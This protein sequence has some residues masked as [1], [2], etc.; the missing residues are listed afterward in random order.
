MVLSGCGVSKTDYNQVVSE[1]T[2]LKQQVETLNAE[3]DQ[4]KFGAEKLTALLK[5]N[6]D[7]N[8]LVSAR[9]N[10]NILTQYHPEELEKNDVK[11]LI[12]QIEKKK[13]LKY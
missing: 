12:I 1:N 13:K 6:N 11:K 9:E 10:I 5:R 3:L 2:K 8:D 4:Y 7:A